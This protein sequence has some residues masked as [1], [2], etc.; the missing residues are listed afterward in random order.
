MFVGGALGTAIR[1]GLGLVGEAAVMT[2]VVN[3]TGALALGWL[4]GRLGLRD[5]APASRARLLLGAGL[6]GSYT[7]YS[8]LA[9]TLAVDVQPLDLWLAAGS[10]VGGL[11]LAAI[12]LRWGSRHA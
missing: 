4:L 8:T 2:A 5:D 9:A 11:L 7:T 12:G 6:L 10:V 3:L 1:Y